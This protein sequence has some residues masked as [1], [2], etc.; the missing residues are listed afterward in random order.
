MVVDDRGLAQTGVKGVVA[1]LVPLWRALLAPS[2]QPQVDA[3]RN[4]LPV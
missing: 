1:C 4:F 3:W 2:A